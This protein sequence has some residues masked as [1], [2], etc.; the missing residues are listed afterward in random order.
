VLRG[1][2]AEELAL[3]DELND[4]LARVARPMDRAWDEA[5]SLMGLIDG[6]DDPDAVRLRIR[7]ALAAVVDRVCVF[8]LADGNKRLRRACVQVWFRCG[9]VREYL[10]AVRAKRGAEPAQCN[11]I[12][13]RADD[14][15]D[16]EDAPLDFANKKD[17]KLVTHMLAGIEAPTARGA[18]K[19]G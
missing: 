13:F 14:P 4:E 1:K 5:R 10:V 8:V 16:K 7:A 17:V 15:R 12:S 2:E 9:A 11:A 6:A 19:V 18:V 3:V